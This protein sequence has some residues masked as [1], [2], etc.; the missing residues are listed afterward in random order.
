M[1]APTTNHRARHRQ[2]GAALIIVITLLA[3]VAVIGIALPGL[4]G[5]QAA[6]AKRGSARLKARY[7]ARAAVELVLSLPAADSAHT[8]ANHT[9]TGDLENGT[10]F[11]STCNHV[12]PVLS[13]GTDQKEGPDDVLTVVSVGTVGR[14]SGQ[15]IR[16]TITAELQATGNVYR[17]INWT[18]K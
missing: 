16:W 11:S 6:L 13:P 5:A 12:R 10:F 1:I 17:V 7:A 4:M 15:P 2:R 14:G 9:F 18:E 8:G 3:V